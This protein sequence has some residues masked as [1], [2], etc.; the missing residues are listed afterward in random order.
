MLK[1][2][3]I[4]GLFCRLFGPVSASQLSLGSMQLGSP[5]N[6]RSIPRPALEKMELPRMALLMAGSSCTQIPAKKALHIG[7]SPPLKAMMLPRSEEH[8][9]ELQSLAYL[10][11]RL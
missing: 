5:S 9:S 1:I 11:C 8:T 7:V 4:T 10:V 6:S 3:M 2:E